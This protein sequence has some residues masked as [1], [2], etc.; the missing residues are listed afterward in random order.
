MISQEA[1]YKPLIVNNTGIRSSNSP[2]A[3]QMNGDQSAYDTQST[4]LDQDVPDFS[5]MM[6]PSS[7]PFAYP[8][9]PMTT[10][11]NYQ[12]IKQEDPLDPS[13]L[14]EPVPTTTGAP[15]DVYDA[16]TYGQMPPFLMPGQPPEYVQGVN[17]SI[18]LSS[19]NP[20]GSSTAAFD[21]GHWPPNQQ[22]RPSNIRSMGFDQLFGEDWGG[23]MNQY[24]Q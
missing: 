7:D 19:E 13:M 14:N 5:A 4:S 23:W 16:Q 10:L 2:N 3:A 21:E 6:F 11:E 17:P 8:N 20:N 12:L 15:F 18:S 24:R 9:Q 22:Q 1:S